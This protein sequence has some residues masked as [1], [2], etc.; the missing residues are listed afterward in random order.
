MEPTWKTLP[1]GEA[2]AKAACKE[3]Q[4]F[5]KKV[6]KRA[7]VFKLVLAG[8]STP[9]RTYQ[10]LAR[11]KTDFSRWRFYFGDERC[12]A[13]GHGDRNS[14]MAWRNLFEPAAIPPE[15]VLAMPTE[16]GPRQ[17]A[18]EYRHVV[19]AAHP[20][21]LVLLGMGPD[22]H[23]ASLFPGSLCKPESLVVPVYGAPKPP[24][25][26]VSLADYPIRSATHRLV[27]VS[28]K[29]K[30]RAVRR[31]RRHGDVP[32]ARVTEGVATTVLI[33]EGAASDDA[34]LP[35]YSPRPV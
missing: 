11:S 18:E 12:A 21:D 5:A 31:W 29:A 9:K 4:S 25:E 35:R 7:D 1:D 6:L 14:V 15:H 17:A 32:I 2:V 13:P 23:T 26:R 33:D 8:G 28:G 10:L 22:G 19:I 34:Q 3:I 16:L 27:L 30:A 24:P 20:F